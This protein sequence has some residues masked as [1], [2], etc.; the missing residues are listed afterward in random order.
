M[1]YNVS[2]NS[3][4]ED[5][6]IHQKIKKDTTVLLLDWLDDDSNHLI[7]K[8]CIDLIIGSELTYSGDLVVITALTKI[9]DK[10][11]NKDGIFI[12]ILSDD[13]DVMKHSIFTENREFL[14]F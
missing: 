13:R 9:I 7:Q 8:S 10:Y 6:E 14:Y 12:E 1:K 5:D 4:D 11:L 2:L 3:N